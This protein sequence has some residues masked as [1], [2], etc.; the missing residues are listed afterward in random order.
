MSNPIGVNR[1]LP[2]QEL[3]PPELGKSWSYY[4]EVRALEEKIKNLEN[5]LAALTAR[6]EALENN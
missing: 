4:Q 6:V 3:Y 2:C 1:P 5:Q